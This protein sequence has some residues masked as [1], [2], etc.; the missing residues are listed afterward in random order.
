MV[1]LL[2]VSLGVKFR[3]RRWSV[4]SS[5]GWKELLGRSYPHNKNGEVEFRSKEE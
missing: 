2:D 1:D 5:E 4:L 3:M